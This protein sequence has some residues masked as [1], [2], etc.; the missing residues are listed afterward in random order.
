MDRPRRP[1]DQG[2]DGLAGPDALSLGSDARR[3]GP[4]D[5][6]RRDR[7]PRAFAGQDRLYDPRRRGSPSL[8]GRSRVPLA[9]LRRLG[10]GGRRARPQRPRALRRP[11]RGK[12]RRQ[13]LE[14]LH[15]ALH[16]SNPRLGRGRAALRPLRRGRSQRRQAE[17]GP[18]R[19]GAGRRRDPLVRRP[20]PGDQAQIPLPGLRRPLGKRGPRAEA[21]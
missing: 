18:R 5:E 13:V 15:G 11:E 16:K 10:R 4:G 1:A 6:G 2:L 9:P 20:D 17:L 12:R 14:A 7:H 3:L 8:E 19:S 21:R